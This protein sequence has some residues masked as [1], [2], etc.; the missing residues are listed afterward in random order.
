MSISARFLDRDD[1][2]EHVAVVALQERA[3][4]DDH[5]D[6][7]GAGLDGLARLEQLHVR[8]GLAGRKAG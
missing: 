2:V 8:I 6:L 7:V 5:V 1:L 4:V 3:A